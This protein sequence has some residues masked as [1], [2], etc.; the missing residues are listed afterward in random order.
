[1]GFFDYTSLEDELVHGLT[2]VERLIPVL[3][4]VLII[5]LI[6]RYQDFFKNFKQ[7]KNIRITLAILMVIG[8]FA[9]YG[10]N[11]YH[12]IQGNVRYITTAPLHLCSY[13]I[14]GLI[15]VLLTK[16]KWVFTT[17]Y[18]FAV[19]SVLALV[20]PNLNHGFNS[21]RYY[22][23]YYSHGLLIITL[24]Y[25]Y[26]IHDFYPNKKEFINSFLVLQVIIV[27][28]LIL[29]VILDTDFL[30]IG[31][32]NKPIDFAWDWPLHMI[33]YEVVMFVLYYIFYRTIKQIKGT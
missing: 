1:M 29:N 18:M 32:G 22:Q 10:W 8:E 11:I 6:Y 27:Y 17:V 24:F 13:A 23:L 3:L 16:K 25:L 2:L 31:P 14:W 28:S 20:F 21:F 30:F 12:H 5:V 9:Y 19:V 4:I 26:K 33:Q 15:I 7:E